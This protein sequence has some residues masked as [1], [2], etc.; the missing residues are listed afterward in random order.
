LKSVPELLVPG[1]WRG[2]GRIVV[3]DYDFDIGYRAIWR[4]ERGASDVLVCVQQVFRGSDEEPLINRLQ[5]EAWDPVQD[6]YRLEILVGEGGLKLSGSLRMEGKS[7]VWKLFQQGL[8]YGEEIYTL[9]GP[10]EY[11]VR[12]EYGSKNQVHSI[13]KGSLIREME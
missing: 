13:I 3:P 2:E 9:V 5:I 6:S 11:L 4:L 1:K 10:G 7:L 8:P 12:A